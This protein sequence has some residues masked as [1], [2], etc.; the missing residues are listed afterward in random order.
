MKNFLKIVYVLVLATAIHGC[1]DNRQDQQQSSMPWQ[2]VELKDDVGV[3]TGYKIDKLSNNYRACLQ[4]LDRADID[5]TP[6]PDRVSPK[7]CELKQQV[8]L[9]RSRYPYTS[10][11]SGTCPIIAAVIS[12][13]D[14]VVFP[15]AMKYF[16]QDVA[17]ITHYAM[18]SCRNIAGTSK[19]SEH[20]KANAIDI[21]AFELKDG[22]KISVLNDWNDQGPKGLFLRSVFR[23]SCKIFKG[24][25]GPNYNA[26]H[27]DHFHFDMGSWDSCD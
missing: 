1:S 25:L 18:F 26:A 5:Y 4:A 7:G 22:T 10:L 14:N 19:R 8:T 23:Q 9:D 24:A 21:S 2:D 12:W 13:E 20:S 16:N 6:V 15:T 17:K 11:V 27:K 3:F